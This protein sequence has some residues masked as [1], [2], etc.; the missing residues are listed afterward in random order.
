MNDTTAITGFLGMAPLSLAGFVTLFGI[1]MAASKFI[2][3]KVKLKLEMK[4]GEQEGLAAGLSLVWSLI[5]LVV[6][7]LALKTQL[8][9]V[10]FLLLLSSG[11]GVQS[12]AN[13]AANRLSGTSDTAKK[14]DAGVTL[15]TNG[16]Q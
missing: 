9:E 11:V 1:I 5:I 15:K 10:T 14:I 16:G 4:W 12:M 8:D 7:W 13:S 2:I 3:Q 6:M